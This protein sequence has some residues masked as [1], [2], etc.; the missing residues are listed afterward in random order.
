MQASL[1]GL[2]FARIS[3]SSGRS[4]T[5]RFRWVGNWVGGLRLHLWSG[6]PG[7]CRQGGQ[8]VLTGTC[9]PCCWVAAAMMS[10][11]HSV[12]SLLPAPLPLPRCCCCCCSKALS[13]YRGEDGVYRLAFRVANLRQHQ[14]G[15]RLQRYCP[16]TALG[17]GD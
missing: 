11:A 17:A 14:V 16:G 10:A 9:L 15:G 6:A 4:A 12:P 2:V 13:M 8:Q 5:I 7:V 3:N 1:L